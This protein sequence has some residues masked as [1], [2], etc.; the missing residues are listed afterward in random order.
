MRTIAVKN[1]YTIGNH[2]RFQNHTFRLANQSISWLKE[3][4]VFNVFP[5]FSIDEEGAIPLSL[6]FEATLLQDGYRIDTRKGEIDLYYSNVR[7]LFYALDTLL[8]HLTPK[9]NAF[10]IPSMVIED[11]PSQAIRGI[12]EGYYGTP[13]TFEERMTL[14]LFMTKHRLNA[15]MYGPKSDPYHRMQW[16]DPYPPELFDELSTFFQSL[17]QYSIMPWFCLSPS[18]SHKGSIPIQ[19]SSETD[20]QLLMNKYFAFY[21]QGIRHFGL[22]YDD[23]DAL[24]SPQDT[25]VFHRV[26]IAHAE[27]ANRVYQELSAKQDPI[28]LVMCP[29]EYHELADSIYRQDLRSHLHPDIHVFFT[30]DNV[31]AEA[32]TTH[33]LHRA[34]QQFGRKV[35]IWDNF[36]VSDFTYGVREFPSVIENRSTHMG[37]LTTG[38][39]INP[40]IHFEISKIGMISM[41]L[42]A[43]NSE[44]YD[45][46]QAYALCFDEV[47]ERLLALG[48]AFFEHNRQ[49]ILSD[50]ALIGE[51]QRFETFK[52]QPILAYYDDL[53]MACQ[54]LLALQTPFIVECAP[55]LKRALKEVWIARGY[56]DF[57]LTRDHILSF[58]ED[59]HFSGSQLI[60]RIIQETKQL[61]EKE[62]EELIT[63]RRGRQW[64]R[65]FEAKRW[66]K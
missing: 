24:L 22:F 26:G 54:N 40:S 7:S 49:S 3:I 55:W 21:D 29:T 42:Y 27:L 63:N 32:I 10:Q 6:R 59:I 30:G 61:T 46:K 28:A 45:S 15:Y 56:F 20:F 19:Y 14:P 13:W 39:F 60:D 65:V 58:L 51:Q 43:W 11:D 16:K 1:K 36:P 17:T 5:S 25:Q 47:D 8:Q 18:Y 62:I 35:M 52:K 57:T 37:E 64:Y 38:Y 66:L 41:A 23:I 9:G 34:N 2:F 50:Q 48:G 31:C 33:D 53:E 4:G 44:G 12:I